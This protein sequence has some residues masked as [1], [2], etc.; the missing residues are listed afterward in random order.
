MY[1]ISED[2]NLDT[3]TG[4]Y[5]EDEGSWLLLQ[6]IGT[7]LPN[8]SP[9]LFIQNFVQQQ[10]SF[11]QRKCDCRTGEKF[12]PPQSTKKINEAKF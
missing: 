2:T 4:Q 12:Y 10:K 8:N 3:K 1:H 9:S 11:W 7:Y 6:I 5:H